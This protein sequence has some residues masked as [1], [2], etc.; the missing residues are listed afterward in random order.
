M[1]F[2]AYFIILNIIKKFKKL[3]IMK[4]K[5]NKRAFQLLKNLEILCFIDDKKIIDY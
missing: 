4:N 3:K 1:K 5:M 2:P